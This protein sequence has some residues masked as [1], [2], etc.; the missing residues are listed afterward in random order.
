MARVAFIVD[1]MF[2]DSE[3]RVPYD[4]VRAAG[5]QAVIIG[6]EAGKK[7]E[8]KKGKETILTEKAIADVSADQFDALVI[9]GGYS[10]DRL[11]LDIKMVGFT[12]ELFNADKPRPMQQA[13]SAIFNVPTGARTLTSTSP[14]DAIRAGAVVYIRT[15]G[16]RIPKSVLPWKN[17]VPSPSSLYESPEGD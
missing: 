5:H 12:R 14:S 9:P 4:R 1:Q 6:T 13:L 16:E 3:F 7:L 8:G 2:E 11:R 15:S 17:T 10:P